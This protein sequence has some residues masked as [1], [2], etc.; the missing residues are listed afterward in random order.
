MKLDSAHL[1]YCTNIHPAETWDE[2]F[3]MLKTFVLPVRDELRASGVLQQ[4]EPYA[5]G[6]RLSAIAA[7]ALLEGDTLFDFKAWLAEENCYVFT[8]NGFPYGQF[9]ETSVKE[10]V[11]RP[12]WQSRE[13]VTYTKNLF[14]IIGQL[15]PEGVS[16]SVSTSPGSFKTF[17]AN[18]DLMLQHYAE[19]AEFIESC[20]EEYQRDLHL[21]IEPEPFGY[22][23]TTDET[24]EFFNQLHQAFPSLSPIIEKRIGV[25]Y[26]TC[27]MAIQYED[28]ATSL[29]K[30]ADQNIRISKIHLSN[31]PQL[32]PQVSEELETIRQFEEPTYL[33]QVIAKKG[34]QL[35]RYKDLNEA[36]AS[37]EAL[38]AEQWRVHFHIPLYANHQATLSSTEVHLKDS[39]HYLLK[40]KQAC[41]H[42]EMETYTWGVMPGHLS[43]GIT[44]QITNE[45]AWVLDQLRTAD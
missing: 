14:H 5:I 1:A 25:N 16:G 11:Y 37:Q 27:H 41:E 17:D 35:L 34:S 40:N 22:L 44:T 4:E 20:S 2:T 45:Y 24:I 13:R 3:Q 31:A 42:L 10:N 23:E 12:D 33:H 15:V 6:L 9:H 21:G 26:D 32:S 19:V 18:L 8:I 29:K 39:I 38:S 28:A 30:L 36:L 43:E 7:E